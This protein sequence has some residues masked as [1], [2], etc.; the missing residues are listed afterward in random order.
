M[1][2]QSILGPPTFLLLPYYLIKP[3]GREIASGVYLLK[4]ILK[5][6]KFNLLTILSSDILRQMITVSF[7]IMILIVGGDNVRKYWPHYFAGAQGIVRNTLFMYLCL[8][9]YNH[10]KSF[11]SKRLKLNVVTNLQLKY[12]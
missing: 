7:T 3:G 1:G 6:M 12:S 5:L 2:A 11:T 10:I 8:L 9:K 4:L